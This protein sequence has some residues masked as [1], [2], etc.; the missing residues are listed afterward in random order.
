MTEICWPGRCV[1][2]CVCVYGAGEIG[3]HENDG[4][5]RLLSFNPK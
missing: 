4:I 1:C 5:M 2:V 3:I